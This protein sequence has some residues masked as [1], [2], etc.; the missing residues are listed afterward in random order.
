MFSP[1]TFFA[2]LPGTFS[3]QSSAVYLA[4]TALVVALINSLVLTLAFYVVVE[5]FSSILTAFTVLFGTLL[6]PL[7]AV[8]ANIPP[9][10]VPAAVESFAKSGGLQVGILSAKLG[11]FLFVGYFGTIVMSTCLQSGIAHGIARLLGCTG[12]FRATA[13]TYSFGSAAWMLSVIPLV[14]V[15]APIYGFALDIFG[16][17]SAHQVSGAKATLT[18]AAAT[19]VSAITF[20]MMLGSNSFCR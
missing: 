3:Y 4:K 11:A 16:I 18:V 10:K 9:D 15:L 7:I 2:E 19:A 13:A 1:L 8:A 6:T 17:R 14:N 20:I 5:S 12:S